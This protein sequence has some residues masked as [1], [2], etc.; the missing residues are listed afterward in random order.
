MAIKISKKY[1]IIPILYIIIIILLV[2]M[3]FGVKKQFSENYLY[4]TLSGTTKSSSKEYEKNILSLDVIIH[5]IKLVF[6]NSTPLKI[7]D[8]NGL[9][10][11]FYIT[12]YQKNDSSIDL[13]FPENFKIN[14]AAI[15]GNENG[16]LIKLESAPGKRLKKAI[17]PF[18]VDKKGTVLK[19]ANFPIFGYKTEESVYFLTTM[20]DDSIIDIKQKEI[21]LLPNKNNSFALNISE[22][23]KGLQDPTSFWLA[24]NT[25]LLQKNINEITVEQQFVDNSYKGWRIDRFSQEQGK[26]FDKDRQPIYSKE[27]ASALGSELIRRRAV[28]ANQWIFRLAEARNSEVKYLETALI[29]GNLAPAYRQM[30]E[31][32]AAAI[33]EITTKIKQ[34]NISVFL[35]DG[36]VKIITD[37]GPYSAI[38]ELFA[39]AEKINIESIDVKTAIGLASAYLDFVFINMEK[40]ISLKKF[41]T[42]VDTIILNKFIINDKGLFMIVMGDKSESLYTAKVAVLLKK[43]AKITERPVLENIGNRLAHSL[44]L[45]TDELG[46]L[47]ESIYADKKGVKNSEGKIEPEYIY[48]ALISAQYMPAVRTLKDYFFPGTWIAT[49]ASSVNAVKTSDNK[50]N[51]ET[52]FPIGETEN[53]IIQGIPSVSRILFYGVNWNSASDFERYYTGWVYNSETQ[54]LFI[55]LQHRQEKEIIEI[56]F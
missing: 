11:K 36:L 44:I 50:F 22:A 7:E 46:L 32:D 24:K 43:A 38:Q 19:S 30:Q 55:K 28:A 34:N 42:I 35:I 5:G 9:I 40:E 20:D 13:F 3:H 14:I 15:K 1:Y 47:P 26:W 23:E 37:R 53:I 31:K 49:C 52:T 45:F 10:S 6:S 8:S 29:N 56:S 16:F 17:I 54:T 21:T 48:P 18:D 27:I 12:G 4:I 25:D 39:M 41:N 33:E 51:I 2:Y